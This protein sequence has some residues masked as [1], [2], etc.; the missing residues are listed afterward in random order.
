M[1]A[2]AA[3]G[4]S[5][6]AVLTTGAARGL[7]QWFVP[8]QWLQVQAAVG[9]GSAGLG[10]L[11]GYWLYV[12]KATVT[13]NSS[14]APASGPRSRGTH[15]HWQD[16]MHALCL[17]SLPVPRKQVCAPDPSHAPA[18]RLERVV[19]VACAVTHHQAS[20]PVVSST[21]SAP[22]ANLRLSARLRLLSPA[23]RRVGL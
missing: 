21:D 6:S 3:A 14:Y 12:C 10:K 19:A 4:C 18:R 11:S 22:R 7:E 9:L 8:T 13:E 5:V 20:R 23:T 15:C 16:I 1:G 2:R 17:A